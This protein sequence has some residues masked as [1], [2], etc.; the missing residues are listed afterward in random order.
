MSPTDVVRAIRVSRF[1]SQWKWT[2]AADAHNNGMSRQWQAN[3]PEKVL[4]FGSSPV[5]QTQ[6]IHSVNGPRAVRARHEQLI[7]THTATDQLTTATDQH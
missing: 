4:T 6:L 1:W 2:N 7:I 3:R 5:D